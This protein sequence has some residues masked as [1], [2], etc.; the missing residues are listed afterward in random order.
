MAATK[1]RNR[2]F[3]VEI[4]REGGWEQVATAT[5]PESATRSLVEAG[6]KEG[7]ETF[8]AGRVVA[9]S[10]RLVHRIPATGTNDVVLSD[11]Q[12]E[13]LAVE[14]GEG[15][16]LADLVEQGIVEAP[17][18]DLPTVR[19]D[20]QPRQRSKS[21]VDDSREEITCTACGAT[22]AADQFPTF[23][24]PKTGLVLR[25]DECRKC[26]DARRAAKKA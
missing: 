16:Y 10:G 24:Q 22:K 17:V 19:A 6:M 14:M 15:D 13:A 20:G 1:T 18:L 12:C 23:V 7:K 9:P 2:T 8:A 21:V 4:L 25:K 3:S 11:A 26:R 5:R